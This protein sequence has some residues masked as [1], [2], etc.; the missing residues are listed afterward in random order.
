MW[1]LF[2]GVMR[3]P[4]PDP[5]EGVWVGLFGGVMRWRQPDPIE[6]GCGCGVIWVRDVRDSA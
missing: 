4:Q 1:G 6:G 2:G 5:M 3:W